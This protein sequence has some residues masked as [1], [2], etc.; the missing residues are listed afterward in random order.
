MTNIILS[1]NST[2]YHALEQLIDS[3]RL[4]FFAGLPG[5]GKSLL[6]QQ[7]ALMAHQAGRNVYL[8]QW[9]VARQP[10]ETDAYVVKNY[11]EVD[12]ITHGAVRKAVG[13]WARAA[14]RRWYHHHPDQADMLIGEVPLV[15]N[16]MIELVQRRDD[17]AEPILSSST[18]RFV[19]PVPSR[20]LRRTIEGKRETSSA[21]PQ[22]EREH[23]D[24]IPQVLQAAW[25]ELYRVAHKLGITNTAPG[26][27][28][29]YEPDIYEGV[30]S[31]LM[32]HRRAQSLPMTVHLPT[33][34]VSVYDLHVQQSELVPK[35]DEV[36]TYVAQVEQL[37]PDM[38]S[39]DREI[40]RWYV[41]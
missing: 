15:G 31:M 11:P 13:L 35:T 23:T 37:Y 40:D 2:L 29:D 33:E 12:G 20:D 8:L 10:F 4:V 32:Q 24:A 7:L 5:V 1:S 27:H 16:R 14:I 22:H 19:I 39:L 26:Q 3:Q 28:I 36:R 41:V 21:N 9:D 30:Y 34:H 17:D 38:T 25:L 6:S 18:A